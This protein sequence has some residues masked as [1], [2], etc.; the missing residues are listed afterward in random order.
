ML[1]GILAISGCTT[2]RSLDPKKTTLIQVDS[3]KRL[4]Y[5]ITTRDAAR[6]IQTTIFAEP[7]PDTA[8]EAFRALS[9]QGRV[10]TTQPVGQAS[11][12][13]SGSYLSSQ[14]V[15][16]LT[17]RTSAVVL[18]R[19]SLYRLTEARANGF[20]TNG[21]WKVGFAQ[22]VEVA[23]KISTFDYTQLEEAKAATTRA[24][25]EQ[26]KAEKELQAAEESR[27]TAEAQKAVQETALKLQ[28]AELLAAR[29]RTEAERRNA[30]AFMAELKETKEALEQSKVALR[31]ETSKFKQTTEQMAATTE[32]QLKR[33]TQQIT[34]LRE[35]EETTKA[36]IEVL[37]AKF[38]NIP[39]DEAARIRKTGSALL[40]SRSV[41]ESVKRQIRVN[42]EKL[43]KP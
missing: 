29:E 14:D 30:E 3:H 42:L 16:E 36:L 15:V 39:P 33:L 40:E 25:E 19:D 1:A 8:L 21:E 37:G 35:R 38:D 23:S 4:A 43:P 11:A 27:R 6:G 17:K 26:K 24:V 5:V 7:P 41:D 13:A 20:I 2:V 31:E 34:D 10:G 9:G 18:L 22:V 32:E 28:E 12:E